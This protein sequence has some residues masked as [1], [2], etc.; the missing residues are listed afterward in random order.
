MSLDLFMPDIPSG[1]FL[2]RPRPSRSTQAV[3][4]A[5]VPKRSST[6]AQ[7]GAGQMRPPTA[8][9]NDGVRG[10]YPL[11]DSYVTTGHDTSSGHA[12]V[13][14]GFAELALSAASPRG[15]RDPSRG[16]SPRP[17]S[18]GSPH[19][20]FVLILHT[21]PA[22]KPQEG[23]EDVRRPQRGRS[24]AT[25]GPFPR[26]SVQAGGSTTLPIPL[27]LVTGSLLLR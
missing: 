25:D 19:H 17:I 22:E 5:R 1:H 3:G 23:A 10:P 27:R 15:R 7:D 12:V 26:D 4:F 14:E 24:G 18:Q 20:A 16:R 9:A 21:S 6:T 2:L 8:T 13:F 11:P